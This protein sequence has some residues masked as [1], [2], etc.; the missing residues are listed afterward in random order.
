MRPS[1]GASSSPA[2]PRRAKR[3]RHFDTVSRLTPSAEATAVLVTPGSAQASTM[4]DRKRQ[5]LSGLAPARPAL[6]LGPV[7]FAQIDDN[8]MRSRHDVLLG[9]RVPA[10]EAHRTDCANF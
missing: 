7:G 10:N 6:Q 2:K 9:P 1:G 3:L 8:R 4:R 5:R